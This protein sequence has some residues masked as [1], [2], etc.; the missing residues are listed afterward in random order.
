MALSGLGVSSTGL[1][2]LAGKNGKL[3]EEIV[4]GY[5]IILEPIWVDGE[6]RI[7]YVLSEA[8]H[9]RVSHVK[10]GG[11]NIHPPHLQELSR[12]Y[13]RLARTASWIVISGSIPSG[14]SPEIYQELIALANQVEI[15][16]LL[17]T[18]GEAALYAIK[19]K[20]T[21]MKFNRDEFSSTFEVP[22]SSSNELYSSAVQ[23]WRQFQIQ[24]W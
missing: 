16:V 14:I 6:T 23:V 18:S 4:R 24:S 1:T 12:F 22:A 21:I 17:D 11:L 7:C 8:V 5:G 2:F 9:G 3:L 15:P 10:V 13:S 20:P 19:T